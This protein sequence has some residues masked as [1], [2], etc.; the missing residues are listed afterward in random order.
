MGTGAWLTPPP[1]EDNKVTEVQ[2]VTGVA[3]R[4]GVP[5]ENGTPQACNYCGA[6]RDARGWHDQSCMSGGDVV[7][8]HNAIREAIFDLAKRADFALSLIHN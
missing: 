1:V 7:R 5:L 4:L 6:A 3:A 2:F 8:R